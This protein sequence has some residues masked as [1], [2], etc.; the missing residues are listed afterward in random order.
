M[1]VS[2]WF[3]YEALYCF[4]KER[5]WIFIYYINFLIIY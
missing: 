1:D 2:K 4:A 5:K 3:I